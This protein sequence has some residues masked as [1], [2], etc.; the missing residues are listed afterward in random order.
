MKTTHENNHI[1]DPDHLNVSNESENGNGNDE[2]NDGGDDDSI[3]YTV[4][5]KCK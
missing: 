4:M 1:H 3:D 2:M 5:R